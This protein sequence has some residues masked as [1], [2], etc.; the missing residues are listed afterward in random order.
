[1]HPTSTSDVVVPVPMIIHLQGDHQ[2][3][4]NSSGGELADQDVAEKPTISHM[5][6]E[7]AQQA[8]LKQQTI[9]QHPTD[10]EHY[11]VGP[12]DLS[13]HS[14]WPTFLRMDGS[15]LPRLIV[16]LTFVAIWSTV[17]TCLSQ[18]RHVN[19]AA[20][21]VL[22]TVLG[23]VVGLALSF[24]S[25]TAYERYSEG[26][27]NWSLLIRTSRNMARTIWV[28]IDE[29]S[30][31][32]QKHN[33]LA[34]LT[35]IN[36]IVAFA[37][38]L[39]HWLR[40]EPSITYKDLVAL[41]SHLRTFAGE[42]LEQQEI[43]PPK[44]TPWKAVGEYLGLSFASS[45]PRKLMKRAKK[46]VG[47]LPLEILNHLSAYIDSCVEKKLLP[48]AIH[49]SQLATGMASLNEV[50][51]ET[52]RVRDTPL[53]EAYVIAISQ[54]AWI[55]ILVLP[56][57][58]IGTLGWITIPGCV[59]SAYIILSLVAIGGELEDPFGQDVNDLPL[60]SYCHQIAQD[61]DIIAATPS[62]KLKD[63]VNNS[64][65]LVLYPL[66]LDG[67]ASWQ[68]RSIH[69]IRDALKAKV[70]ARHPSHSFKKRHSDEKLST[71]SV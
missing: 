3:Q 22:L 45:N 33:V 24:R 64:E 15:I 60:D 38:A 62:A 55:Y 51:T 56:F 28:N 8:E 65:N 44:K 52:E 21:N 43:P 34:K 37:V 2:T 68:Q 39:K 14:K 42:A 16:P 25:A 46:P 11:F 71:A 5:T 27:K 48:S 23:F 40:F 6:I 31:E 54:I 12:R 7:E 63:F 32:D 13:K 26:R 36:L 70:T 47:H 30:E 29:G 66:S 53:P 50:L 17:F 67:Y 59:V 41:V 49:Q 69:D 57:Q 61:L 19:L 18:I 10:L 9:V 35:A 20:S 1:M 4:E 58:L